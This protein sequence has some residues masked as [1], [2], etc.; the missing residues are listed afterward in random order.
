M[1][2]S[3]KRKRTFRQKL[4]GAAIITGSVVLI[5]GVI[6]LGIGL[7]FRNHFLLQT[8]I[9]GLHVGGMTAPEA[10]EAIAGN[11]GKYVLKVTGRDGASDKISG[12]DLGVSYLPE[13]SIEKALEEQNIFLWLPSV[14][15]RDSVEVPT[16]MDFDESKLETAV[17][18]MG[19][20]QP[21]KIVEPKDANLHLEKGGY[22]LVPEVLGTKLVV[23]RVIVA[24]GEAVRDGRGELALTDEFYENPAVT[25]DD[26]QLAGAMETIQKYLQTKVTYAVQGEAEVL[27]KEKILPMIVL[28]EDYSVSLD[29][30]KIT[31]Y[32]QTL[33]SKYNTFG[34]K[35]SFQTTLGNVVEIGGGDYGWVV[36][37]SKEAEALTANLLAGEV[38]SRPPIWEQTAIVEGRDDIGD[39]Y[40]E[41]DYSNQHL[42][43]YVEGDLVM[44]FDV[45][46]GN[47]AR[48]NGSPDG[49]YKVVY[50]KSPAVLRGEDYEANVK[51]FMV[52]A[53]NV[54]IHDASWRSEFGGQ[55]YKTSGSHGC[56]N[57]P[58]GMAKELYAKLKV[59]TPV[60]AYYREPVVLTAE[61][62]K[63]SNAFSYVKVAARD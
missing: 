38:I 62:A 5:L 20:F 16:P 14:L 11:A 48:N 29:S 56:I 58:E 25:K 51:Y 52:F 34:R 28:G 46:T 44:D 41:I 18:N 63:I 26:P 23:D 50:K 45:V 55:F 17:V 40:I 8:E 7:Y 12:K 19:F 24:V 60:V 36:S 10:E 39:T 27:D 42:Y 33:A 37:K 32:V 31:Q 22:V 49:V 2:K 13:G 6:Y 53:Y 15:M 30:E 59:D 9:N 54:G 4:A 47:V 43:Y 61:N 21:G 1:G 57:S 35:R 3:K